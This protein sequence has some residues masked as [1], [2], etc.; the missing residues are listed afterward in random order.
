MGLWI[1]DDEEEA[2]DDAEEVGRDD[3]RWGMEWPDR[4][5]RGGIV[6]E[7]ARC[8]GWFCVFFSGFLVISLDICRLDRLWR[9]LLCNVTL[10]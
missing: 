8:N 6:G 5:G 4:A 10:D 2:M 3:R 9:G 1:L 7:L